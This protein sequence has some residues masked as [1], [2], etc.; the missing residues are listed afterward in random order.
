MIRSV[1]IIVLVSTIIATTIGLPLYFDLR[2]HTENEA[3]YIIESK[4]LLIEDYLHRISDLSGQISTRT[5]IREDLALYNAGQRTREDLIALNSPKLADS[6]RISKKIAGIAQLDLKGKPV[7]FVGQAIPQ[8]ALSSLQL[9]KTETKIHH[10]VKI[11]GQ[12]YL[13]SSAPILDRKNTY[14]GSNVFISS[15]QA[16]QEIIDDTR[17]L[18]QLCEI[19]LATSENSSLKILF[20]S[21]REKSLCD[22]DTFYNAIDT[23][24]KSCIIFNRTIEPTGWQLYYRIKKSELNHLIDSN[25]IRL[26]VIST[27]IIV[28][29]GIGIFITI[30]PLLEKLRDEL[31]RRKQF[32]HKLEKSIDEKNVLLQEIHHRS[33]NNL[34]VISSLIQIKT[35]Q[36]EDPKLIEVISE[37]QGRIIAMSL[38]HE[39][40]Y[41]S[42]D[43]VNIRMKNFFYDLIKNI[44]CAHLNTNIM[45]CLDIDESSLDINQA[46]PC[47]ILCNELLTNVFKHA[48]PHNE[49]GNVLVR[50]K[51][52]NN[53]YE[54]KIQDSG[55]GCCDDSCSKPNLGLGL[56][57]NLATKQLYGN[58][59]INNNNNGCDIIVTFPF[60]P[61]DSDHG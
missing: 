4:K 15:T 53:G 23:T 29:A 47:A 22:L 13:L 59:T 48:F 18:A 50:F 14:V 2:D 46:I 35:R 25:M 38:V 24:C 30:H 58:V 43:L 55:V 6:I 12:L 34:Q 49:K 41:Q 1:A 28:L 40:L 56:V 17:S 16:L 45:F 60:Q 44:Q 57:H 21:D 52:T 10:P 7:I 20:S 42:D 8:K 32:E 33:K 9:P 31:Q 19:I 26:A 5:K 61:K 36:F 54:L 39:K 11:D 51:K 3:Q 27:V 37:I